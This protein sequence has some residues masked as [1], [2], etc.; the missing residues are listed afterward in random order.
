MRCGMVWALTVTIGVLWSCGACFGESDPQ[1][2]D[3]FEEHIR[4][5]LAKH[6]VQCHGE[7]KQESNL[8]LDTLEF[9]LAGG[10]SGP[11]ITKG[12]PQESLL[13]EAIKYESFEMPPAGQLD[14]RRRSSC[15]R[16]GLPRERFGRKTILA[17][18][19]ASD[20]RDHRRR[21]SL[22]GLPATG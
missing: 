14:D 11:A 4:P 20:A 16:L 5:V 19:A 2:S 17:I 22:V 3:W 9:V 21:S 10:D 8:R 1:S 18:R 6:C 13:I 15:L 12:E 7:N